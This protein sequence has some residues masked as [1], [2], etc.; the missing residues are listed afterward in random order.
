[1]LRKEDKTGWIF[2]VDPATPFSRGRHPLLEYSLIPYVRMKIVTAEEAIALIPPDG[3][4]GL[5]NACGEPQTLIE[6]LIEACI[7]FKGAQLIGMIQFSSQRIWKT[8]RG[9]HFTW[10]T[11]MMDPFL[12][13]AAREG[14]ADY[15]PCRY[16]EIP[17]LFSEKIL[18][19]DVALVSV[20]P[21]GPDGSMSLGVSVDHTFAMAKAA[22]MVIGEINQQMPW[23]EGETFLYPSQIHYAIQTDRS[24][25]Q[26]NTEPL[27]EADRKIGSYIASLIPDGATI[28][29][30]IGKI[31]H[32]FLASL[33]GKKHL[34]IHSGLLVDEI[35]DL[36]ESG[37]I[38]NSLKVL[39]RG[40]IIGTT[41]IG[42]DRLYRFVDRNPDVE[43]YP[44]SYTHNAA[45]LAQL[46]HFYSINGA[47]QVDLSGQVNAETVSGVQV[48][49]IGGQSDF[50]QGA[51]LS[52]GG[53]SIIALFSTTPEEKTSRIVAHLERDAAVSSLRHDVDYVVTE[54]GIASLQGK[55][56]GERARALVEISHPSFRE[57][58]K[59]ESLKI[60][61]K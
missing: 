59:A 16:S 60:F 22:K 23:V 56:L 5:G 10:K 43:S 41:M 6:A 1:L 20:S 14:K 12:V 3:V 11:F 38:D 45:I 53:R 47:L 36:I 29:F 31:S 40:K 35:V 50:V 48:S 32:S 21:P 57:T 54:Y 61:S 4:I 26:V 15:I 7:R 27:T 2:A 51:R 33:R 58:L 18:P 37:A 19:L 46:N 8:D 44:S 13:E 24:L 34:G 9:T 55:S 25:P 39:H 52:R 49:G 17:L 30:G 42:T 28:Q